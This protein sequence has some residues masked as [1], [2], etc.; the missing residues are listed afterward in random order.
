VGAACAAPTAGS[1]WAGYIS[2]T[3]MRVVLLSSVTA[4]S[5]A[6]ATRVPVPGQAMP[7]VGPSRRGELLEPVTGVRLPT[8]PAARADLV[9][10][11]LPPYR[12]VLPRT[13]VPY[14]N[15]SSKRLIAVMLGS[16]PVK[17]RK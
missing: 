3:V 5:V 8:T 4:P 14:L 1:V 15:L 17:P 12:Q 13:I 9:S 11:F 6:P 16:V 7:L 10:M 2:L